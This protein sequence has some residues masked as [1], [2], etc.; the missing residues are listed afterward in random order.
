MGLSVSKVCRGRAPEPKQANQVPVAAAMPR[1]QPVIPAGP[2]SD[3]SE[4]PADSTDEEEEVNHAGAAAGNVAGQQAEQDEDLPMLMI[5]PPE[6]FPPRITRISL[7]VKHP[8]LAEGGFDTTMY[9]YILSIRCTIKDWAKVRNILPETKRSRF[10]ATLS[11]KMIFGEMRGTKYI[12]EGMRV[13]WTFNLG[14]AVERRAV[15]CQLLS[16]VL[17]YE[18]DPDLKHRITVC[19]MRYTTATSGKLTEKEDNR[20]VLREFVAFY[21]LDEEAMRL[22]ARHGM[23]RVAQIPRDIGP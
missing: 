16:V 9:P 5:M 14:T 13:P 3:S 10:C 2:P 8:F 1:P 19:F 18:E 7:M 17:G 15:W 20:L 4:F 11:D 21:M 12:C 22:Q 6:R 23:P